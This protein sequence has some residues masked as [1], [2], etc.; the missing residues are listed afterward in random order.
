MQPIKND[1]PTD[2]KIHFNKP[3]IVGKELYNIAQAV[4]N[5]RLAGNGEFTRRCQEYIEK[6]YRAKKALLTTSCTDALEMCALLC[7]IG[8]GDEVI[9]PS[10]TFVST[11]NAFLLRGAKLVF[12][13]I[14][15]KTLNIDAKKIEPAITPRTK[16][17][18]V[19]H[20]AGVGCEMDSILAIAK[21]H[22]LIVVEDA[23]QAMNSQYKGQY[24]GTLGTV[25]AYSFHETKNFISGEGGALI[26]NDE[27]LIE[28]AEI[29]WEKG[30][31]RGKFYRGEVDKYT[32]VDIGSSFL[33]S[34]LTAAF[35]YAQFEMAEEITKRRLT[36]WSYY[37]DRLRALEEKSLVRL[38]FIPE[39][40]THNAHMFFIILNTEKEQKDLLARFKENKILAIFHYI[41][42]HTS[43]MGKSMGYREG[44]L[45][46]TES[47]SMR[48]IRL[49]LYFDITPAEQDSVID[50]IYSFF[51]L[52]RTGE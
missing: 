9:L 29:L 23:A 52:K 1:K 27:S 15:A 5:G 30:T 42:L 34:E 37:R 25:A 35:L 26:I 21:K 12:V 44:Q 18:C 36:S 50:V 49:P 4:L 40:C 2:I 17:I 28:R 20:Y 45:P 16:V 43:P 38:P 3:F 33:P 46:V 47:L 19:V 11:A 10:Y 8:P 24:L 22:S 32:W 51:N 41:P 39:T 48:L 13:D 7:N 31:N 14:N 6:T